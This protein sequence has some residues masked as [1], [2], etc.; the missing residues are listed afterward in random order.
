MKVIQLEKIAHYLTRAPLAASSQGM[1]DDLGAKSGNWLCGYVAK[2]L[3]CRLRF[4]FC[5][6]SAAPVRGKWAFF[7]QG[8][9]LGKTGRISVT[10]R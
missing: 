1:Q 4:Q 8:A 7:A 6:L 5:F 9:Q 2:W 3:S 10:S